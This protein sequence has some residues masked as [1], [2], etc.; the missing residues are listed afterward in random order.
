MLLRYDFEIGRILISLLFIIA[1]LLLIFRKGDFQYLTGLIRS[2]GVP[3]A[4][5][6]MVLTIIIELVCGV[7]ILIGFYTWIAAAV[8][9]VWIVPTTLV[10]HAP[11]KAP[12]EMVANEIYHTIKNVA[13]A[14]GLLLL[15]AAY[16]P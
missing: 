2:R 16:R 7:A 14:G 8:L 9:I 4:K 12:P 15:V 6:V 13:I 3:M 1:A 10:S 11:W 5:F